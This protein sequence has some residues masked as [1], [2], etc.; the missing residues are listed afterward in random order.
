MVKVSGDIKPFRINRD[1]L[2]ELVKLIRRFRPNTKI[3]SVKT[4]LEKI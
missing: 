1:N 4:I 3:F 2:V